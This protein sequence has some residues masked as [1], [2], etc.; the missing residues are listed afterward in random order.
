MIMVWHIKHTVPPPHPRPP[1]PHTQGTTHYRHCVRTWTPPL[2]RPHL[3]GRYTHTHTLTHT[4]THIYIYPP[5]HTPPP[6]TLQALLT[7]TPPPPPCPSPSAPSPPRRPHPPGRQWRGR[8]TGSPRRAPPPGWGCR[9]RWWGGPRPEREGERGERV[10]V[11]F[12]IMSGGGGRRGWALLE[13]KRSKPNPA[14]VCIPTKTPQN[15]I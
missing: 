11:C 14:T 13:K 6:H 5:P 12:E 1:P 15:M 9:R 7:W 3:P 8:A 10:C 2:L 4:H